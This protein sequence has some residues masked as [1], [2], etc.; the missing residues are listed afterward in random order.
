MTRSR[1]ALAAVGACLVIAAVLVAV[2]AVHGPAA[3]KR[4]AAARA[5]AS[6]SPASAQPTA[7][8]PSAA[9][10]EPR[11]HADPFG[12]A[13]ASY[14][15]ARAGT[16]L[17]AVYDLETGQTWSLGTGQPQA[18]AS[19]VKLDVLETLLAQRGGSSPA[20]LSASDQ[21]LAQQMIE[22]SDNDA[23]TSLWYEVGGAAK[24][25]SFNA[26]VGLKRTVPSPCVVC[27]GF[28]W[29]GWGLTTTVPTDQLALL[30]ELVMPGPL[31]TG[32]ERRYAL[33]LMENVT[34]SQR[35]GVS[36]GVPPQA[37]VALKNG[38]LPLDSAGDDWQVNSVG[39]ISGSGRDYLLAVLTTGNPAEQYGID[40]IG[41][42]AALVWQ[43]MG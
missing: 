23:A 35:W 17:A 28:P 30:R 22:D 2:L 16:V 31:L 11:R 41:A 24:I 25:S 26:A 12:P 19:V 6:R 3:S 32:A 40:T 8:V 38:W 43:H 18:E 5:A 39:W 29:P 20:G 9:A 21:S 42:L 13:A 36:G 10:A 14:V 15:A 34:P 1:G 27:A 4:P 7:A 33:S 37:T